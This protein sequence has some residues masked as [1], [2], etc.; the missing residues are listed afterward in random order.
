MFLSLIMSNVLTF[1]GNFLKW[2]TSHHRPAERW[3]RY[4]QAMSL[5]WSEGVFIQSS[6]HT[7]LPTCGQSKPTLQWCIE[8]S[9]EETTLVSRQP[10]QATLRNVM[11]SCVYRL[12]NSRNCIVM[13]FTSIKL[14]TIVKT[15][16]A[17]DVLRIIS[18]HI[19]W[20]KRQQSRPQKAHTQ[21]KTD[22]WTS[23]SDHYQTQLPPS[24]TSLQT[25]HCCFVDLCFN[26]YLWQVINE[27]GRLSKRDPWAH[28]QVQG[29]MWEPKSSKRETFDIY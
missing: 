26:L 22:R 16:V 4:L 20:F 3:R 24:C 19:P 23:G 5:S 1:Q 27:A 14:S 9:P 18:Q 6:V 29:W 13:T 8:N 21:I 28:Y 25:A 7:L 17:Q 2:L 15:A 10:L 11:S 12:N